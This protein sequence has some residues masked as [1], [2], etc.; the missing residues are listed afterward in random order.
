M[1]KYFWFLFLIQSFPAVSQPYRLIIRNTD[2]TNSTGIYQLYLHCGNRRK[3]EVLNQRNNKTVK[4]FKVR[5]NQGD[6]KKMNNYYLISPS[7]DSAL[8]L[9]VIKKKNEIGN[10]N[11]NTLQVPDPRISFVRS[12]QK[13]LLYTG[14]RV[15]TT[16]TLSCQ[17][18]PDPDFAGKCPRDTLYQASQITVVRNGNVR[19]A[20]KINGTF[21]LNNFGLNHVETIKLELNKFKRV[22]YR[23]EE[24]EENASGE[25]FVILKIN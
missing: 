4:K 6:I 7:E 14:F 22:N 8:V 17:F 13:K 21:Q 3:I 10:I 23:G 2:P 19:K 11:F 20:M 25:E 16:D 18:L 15:S 1:K 5:L 24:Y 12:S 9:S